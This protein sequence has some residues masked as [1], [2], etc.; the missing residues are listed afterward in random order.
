MRIGSGDLD[1]V[2]RSEWGNIEV[3]LWRIPEEVEPVM[4][5]RAGT[6]PLLLSRVDFAPDCDFAAVEAIESGWMCRLR[7]WVG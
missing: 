1:E 4:D 6:H 7:N 2:L 3:K 5:F